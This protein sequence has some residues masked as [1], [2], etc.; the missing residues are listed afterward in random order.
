MRAVARGRGTVRGQSPLSLSSSSP[1]SLSLSPPLSIFL[2]PPLSISLSPRSSWSRDPGLF[3]GARRL[4]TLPIVWTDMIRER[5]TGQQ[6]DAAK[7]ESTF[8]TRLC[9]VPSSESGKGVE[10]PSVAT[11]QRWA[12]PPG[13]GACATVAR[14]RPT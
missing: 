10:A 1:A 3:S 2:S 9:Y 6:P 7:E 4:R 11:P 12:S 14:P 8:L 13:H 5:H